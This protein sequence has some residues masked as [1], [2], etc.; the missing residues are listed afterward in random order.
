MSRRPLE[1]PQVGAVVLDLAAQMIRAEVSREAVAPAATYNGGGGAGRYPNA[2]GGGGAGR[3]PSAGAGYY[4]RRDNKTH[5]NRVPQSSVS[6]H[7]LI[8]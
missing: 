5:H 8:D 1:S 7:Q 6:Y 2:G 4:A 3:Y